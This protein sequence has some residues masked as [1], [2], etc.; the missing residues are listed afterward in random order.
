MVTQAAKSRSRKRPACRLGGGSKRAAC[1]Y[2]PAGRNASPREYIEW[3]ENPTA[4]LARK[5]IEALRGLR[6]REGYP[7]TVAE[8]AAGTAPEATAEQVDKALAKKPFAAQV[9]RARKKDPASPVAL[10]EDAERLAD[11]PRLVEI[12]AAAPVQRRQAAAPGGAG[13]VPGGQGA[14]SRR[15]PRHSTPRG[16]GHAAGDGGERPGKGQDAPVFAGVSAPAAEEA[17]RGGVGSSACW[18][19]WRSVAAGGRRNIRCPCSARG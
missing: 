10:A 13:G 11:S 8:L 15:S 18:N 9:L 7:P 6:D 5:L 12:R 4:E 1:G 17:P 3:R 2:G 19:P 16:G 14:V